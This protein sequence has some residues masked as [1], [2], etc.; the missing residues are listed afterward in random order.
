[1]RLFQQLKNTNKICPAPV[2]IIA[3]DGELAGSLKTYAKE[4]GLLAITKEELPTPSYPDIVFCGH[5]SNP[6]NLMGSIPFFILTSI[7]EG[8][9]LVLGEAMLNGQCVISIDCPTGP[10]EF[11]NDTFTGRGVEKTERK[12]Y[13]ILFPY[14]TYGS[15]QKIAHEIAALISDKEAVY[16]MRQKAKVKALQFSAATVQKQWKEAIHNLVITN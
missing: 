8:F 11:L 5:Q 3:G 1:L 15:E 4:L 7:F 14:A 12:A 9:P 2:L 16:D 6:F 10:E 13:G